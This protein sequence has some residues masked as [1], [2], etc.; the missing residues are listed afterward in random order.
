[1]SQATQRVER[2]APDGEAGTSFS[3]DEWFVV[4][5]A[6]TI[7]DRE[8]VFHGFGSPCAQ[9]AMHV[10]RHSHAREMLLVEGATYAVNPDP[11]FIPP[12]GNDLSLQRG[13]PYQ[14]RFEEFFDSAMRGDVDRMF[15]SGGQIDPYGNTNVTAIG[16]LD[17]PKVKLGGGGG[18]C[19][20]AATIGHIT[21]WTTRHRSGRT[22]VERC[23]FVTDMGHR[24]AHGG[25]AELEL[26]GG[27]PQWLVTELGVF[28]YDAYGRARLRQLFPD[29]TL[30]DIRAVTGFEFQVA[31][32]LRT[33]PLPSA[34]EL[35]TLR[36]VDPLGVR[37]SEFA[38]A[39]LRRT[40]TPR[41]GAGCVC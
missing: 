40:F 34:A 39:E 23:D 21:L 41:E 18:G 2:D 36:A 25:R 37:R 12:T 7:R 27:G 3:I 29:V 30:D 6:R 11:P 38:P 5:L 22:L 1:M 20:L 9:V 14:M 8:V 16:P 4:T 24:T 10:A 28:D 19:N 15:L 17:R 33:V 26:T 13:A 35:A 32:D 31:G